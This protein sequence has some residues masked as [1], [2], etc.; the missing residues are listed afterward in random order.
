RRAGPA[1]LGAMVCGGGPLRR[2]GATM[3]QPAF[4]GGRGERRELGRLRPV[5]GGRSPF[6]VAGDGLDP[7]RGLDGGGALCG[8][9]VSRDARRP[10]SATAGRGARAGGSLVS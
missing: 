5:L 8:T 6:A 10:A 7:A 3:V 9:D 1:R 4:R 2:L